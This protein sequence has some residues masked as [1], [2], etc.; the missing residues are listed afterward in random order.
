MDEILVFGGSGSSRLTLGI[1]LRPE[2]FGGVRVVT[3][4][5]PRCC[6][7]SHHAGAGSTSGSFGGRSRSCGGARCGGCGAGGGCSGWG[8]LLLQSEGV[9]VG[10]GTNTAVGAMVERRRP[11]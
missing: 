1:E 8:E 7:R 10:C 11:N 5:E 4:Y 6:Q 2:D 9:L 3:S